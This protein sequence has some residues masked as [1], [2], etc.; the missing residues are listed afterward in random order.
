MAEE[1]PE[2]DRA[3]SHP[4]RVELVKLLWHL[5][6]SATAARLR[7]DL[8]GVETLQVVAYHTRVLEQAG[9]IEVDP[10]SEPTRRAYW[11]GGD[12]ADEATRRLRLWN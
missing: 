1:R 6:D 3:L 12:N 7:D 10:A 8:Q 2:L 11:I 4:I 5:G 9:V